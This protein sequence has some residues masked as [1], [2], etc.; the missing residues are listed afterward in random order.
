M[1]Y[2]IQVIPGWPE[3]RR[4]R[5]NASSREPSI[6]ELPF[7]WDVSESGADGDKISR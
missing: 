4:K 3:T 1:N 2:Q 6:P 7:V 5:S